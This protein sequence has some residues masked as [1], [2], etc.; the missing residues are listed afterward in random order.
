[1]LLDIQV[2]N[3]ALSGFVTVEPVSAAELRQALPPDLTLLVYHLMADE[4]EV[5]VWHN[6]QTAVR[7][8]PVSRDEL[9]QRIRQYR[10]AVQNR[11]LVDQVRRQSREIYGEV[12]EPVADLLPDGATIGIVPHGALHYL[13]FASLYDGQA[14][15]VERHPIFYASSASVLRRTL[16]AAPPA[17]KADFK[18]LAVGNPA[19]GN[20]AYELPFTEQEVVSI[21]RDFTQVTPVTGA[22]AT[23]ANLRKE[24]GDYDVI[25]IAAHGSLDPL[26][27]LFSSLI[28]APQPGDDGLL[29]LYE[30]TGLRLKAQLAALSACESGLGDL[31]SGDE[32]VSLARAFNYAG[33]RTI[34]STLW[35]VDDVATALVVKHFYRQYVDHGAAN[36]LRLAQLQVMNDGL[37][38]HPTY[39]AGVVVTGDYR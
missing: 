18:V 37:H 29:H 25:H 19:V 21:E 26:R 10:I 8:V 1:V 16:A 34:L 32:L 15:L 4:L 9:A 17:D 5:W 11:D 22:Q 24:A 35:R 31:T 7:R 36:S 38:Y 39:W 27:P 20:P 6:G 23:K 14:F 13:S 12:L 2:A 28:L 33:A 30:V 3:P